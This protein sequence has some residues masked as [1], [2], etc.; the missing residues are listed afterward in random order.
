MA[1]QLYKLPL[2][3]WLSYSQ[4]VDFMICKL[5]LKRLFYRGS[6]TPNSPVDPSVAHSQHAPGTLLILCLCCGWSWK[7]S[8]TEN[9][10]W[11]L[12][13]TPTSLPRRWLL[14]WTIPALVLELFIVTFS[15]N[16]L[17]VINSL[18]KELCII[19]LSVLYYALHRAGTQ[20]LFVIVN[21]IDRITCSLKNLL[22][23]W[24]VAKI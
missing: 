20:W 6:K 24:K 18:S 23:A 12:H 8:L 10:L 22:A 5:Y 13:S 9:L 3:I 15:S 11:K 19:H 1:A 7:A 16:L 2:R 4:W 17:P 14:L 21:K